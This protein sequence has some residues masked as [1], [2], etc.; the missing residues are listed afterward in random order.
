[1]DRVRSHHCTVGHDFRRDWQIKLIWSRASR[2][3]LS[4]PASPSL[5]CYGLT[6]RLALRSVE[7]SRQWE[8]FWKSR[9]EAYAAQNDALSFPP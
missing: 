8:N 6:P 3:L 5:S 9:A 4:P 1:M 7:L 2:Q